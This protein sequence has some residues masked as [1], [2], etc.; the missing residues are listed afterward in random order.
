MFA[1]SLL[2][3][4]QGGL[5]EEEELGERGGCT[6]YS[7]LSVVGSG[8]GLFTGHFGWLLGALLMWFLCVM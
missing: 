4:S 2:L 6:T 8:P 5:G 7:Y 3:P 1:F